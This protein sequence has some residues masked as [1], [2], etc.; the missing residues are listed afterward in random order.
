LTFD[1]IQSPE[2]GG[3]YDVLLDGTGPQQ[4]LDNITVDGDGNPILQEDPGNQ[5]HLARIWKFYLRS[6]ELVEIAKHDPARF[7]N[8][9]GAKVTLPTL[10]FSSD[11]ESSGVV[12]I[13]HLLRKNL[14]KFGLGALRPP[15]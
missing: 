12:E 10:P 9:N 14:Q 3:R 2:K 4:M 7:G 6:D 11:E 15:R 5:A 8:R 1:D 13:T